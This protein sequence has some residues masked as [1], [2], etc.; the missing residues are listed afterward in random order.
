MKVASF[1]SGIGGL[2]LGFEKAGFEIIFAN[3]NWK[4]CHETYTKNHSIKINKKSIEDLESNEIPKVDGFIGGPPCQSWSL[5][6]S[7]K[8]RN[9]SRGQL[10]KHYHRLINEKKAKFLFNGKCAWDGM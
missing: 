6:G 3:D 8:G 1:F 4:G 2:E 5:A 9:D 10:L 7:M